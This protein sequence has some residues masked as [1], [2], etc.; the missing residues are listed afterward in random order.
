MDTYRGRQQEHHQA[1]TDPV[2]AHCLEELLYA[3]CIDK[4]YDQD[5]NQYKRE[6]PSSTC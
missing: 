3:M 2:P 4:I 6:G 1:S 5:A